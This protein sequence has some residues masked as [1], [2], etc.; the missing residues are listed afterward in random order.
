MRDS[1]ALSDQARLFGN[2]GSALDLNGQTANPHTNHIAGLLGAC[3]PT[4]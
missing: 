3:R 1:H 4:E 2:S